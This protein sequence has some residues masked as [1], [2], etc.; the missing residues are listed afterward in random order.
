MIPMT[1]ALEGL[2]KTL[3]AGAGWKEV[4]PQL[5]ALAIFI[6]VMWPLGIFAFGRFHTARPVRTDRLGAFAEKIHAK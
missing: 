3:L 1:H 6:G 4:S 5:M 2:Q